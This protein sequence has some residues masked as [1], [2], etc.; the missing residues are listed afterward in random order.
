MKFKNWKVIC[1]VILILPAFCLPVSGKDKPWEVWDYAKEKPVRGGYYRTAGAL[2]VGLLNPNHWP[3]NDWLVIN[4]FFEKYLITDGTYK[5]VPWIAEAWKYTDPK[6]CVMKLNQGITYHD[7]TPLNADSV[8]YNIDWI[9]NP[10]NGCW[11]RGWLAPLKSVE[12]VDEYTLKWNFKEPWAAFLGII[13][14][15]PGYAISKKALETD[16][17]LKEA[18]SVS[19]KAE[20]AK[21]KAL[22][23]RKKAEDAAGSA[24]ADKLTAKAEK[25]KQKAAE[26]KK[27][28]DALAAKVQGA[29]S[30]DVYPVGTGPWMLED[31]SPGNYIKVKRNP[32]WWYGK[33]IGHDMPYFDGIY[34]TVIPDPSVRLA[35]LKAGRI[36]SLTLSKLQYN[37][38]KNDRNLDVY[39]GP[40][41]HVEAM[42]FNLAD[43]PCKD[44][45][46]RQAI[47][48]AIDR[49]AIITGLEFG[50]GREASCMYPDDHWCHNPGLKPVAYDPELS[51]K[52]LAEAGYADGLT[53]KGY[54][55]NSA[56]SKAWAEAIKEMLAQVKVDWQ[57]DILDSVAISDKMKN[58]EYDFAG[59]G[60]TWIYDPDLMA[61]GLYHPEGGFNYGRSNNEAAIKLIEAG[62]KELDPEKR[63]QIYWE[64]EKVLYDNYEDAWLFWEM[65]PVAYNKAVKGYNQPM[66]NTHKEIWSWSHPLWFKGGKAP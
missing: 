18:D 41:N 4:F 56:T 42:R 12:V 27:E 20:R 44:L 64:L 29:Q 19:K 15:V 61:T 37:M 5:P 57:V 48:H 40:V 21:E 47:S 52:L 33:K 6:T 53:I 58:L 63:K 3:V 49:K 24:E 23:A 39:V 30:T 34:H 8:K 36:H 59:G 1:L 54:M 35:N 32:N 38:A 46:V 13:A 22:K 62:R 55:L 43:G 25:E 60:W 10:K 16:I 65:W 50:L 2:D 45:R 7:G 9:L 14:N 66:A 31:R 28:A 26:L 51:R 11:S 17:L